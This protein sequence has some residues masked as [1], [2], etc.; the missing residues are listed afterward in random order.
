MDSLTTLAP[1]LAGPLGAVSVLIML[2]IALKTG[3]LVVGSQQD[4]L[5]AYY[6]GA[7]KNR[8]KQI[9]DWKEIAHRHDERA[10]R[11]MEISAANTLALEKVNEQLR[12]ILLT[13]G[14]RAS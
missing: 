12:Q 7:L 3:Q 8:D 4:K 13:D 2:V 1:L 11:A 9:D 6:D 14:R 5:L 10:D